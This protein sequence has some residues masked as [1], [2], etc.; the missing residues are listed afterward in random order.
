MPRRQTDRT[1]QFAVPRHREKYRLLDEGCLGAESL[2]AESKRLNFLF[3]DRLCRC[4]KLI[5]LVVCRR[6]KL[7]I[8]VVTKKFKK[9]FYF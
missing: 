1:Q 8:L 3:S 9:K 2:S 4:S 7:I 6:S 5:I